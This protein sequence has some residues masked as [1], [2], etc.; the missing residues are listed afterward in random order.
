[1]RRRPRQR[2]RTG[3]PDRLVVRSLV[4]RASLASRRSESCRRRRDGSVSSGWTIAAGELETRE[5]LTEFH[6]LP[7]PVWTFLA[8]R[9]NRRNRGC[10][11]PRALPSHQRRRAQLLA[12]PTS[13]K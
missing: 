7:P 8:P 13:R 2:T 3:P 5:Q 9:Q 6:L 10:L 11:S 1:M 4:N 12:T